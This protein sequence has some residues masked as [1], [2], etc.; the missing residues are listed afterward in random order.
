M[1]LAEV[2]VKCDNID[3]TD[4]VVAV[5]VVDYECKSAEEVEV[6][7]ADDHQVLHQVTVVLVV[8]GAL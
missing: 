2:L 7:W 5:Q 3:F 1:T 4:V 6:V 8:D